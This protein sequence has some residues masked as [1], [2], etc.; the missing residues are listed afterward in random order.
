M[1]VD[2]VG[3]T[4]SRHGTKQAQGQTV[5][6]MLRLLYVPGAWFHHG[7]CAGSDVESAA[8]ARGIGYLLHGHP[9]VGPWRSHA[10]ENDVEEEPEAPLVRNDEIVAVSGI[11]IATPAGRTEVIHSGTWSTIRRARKAQ[12]PH[13]IVWPDGGYNFYCGAEELVR[14]DG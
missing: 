10:I 5:G 14:R 8:R 13:A 6:S 7:C 1:T 4:G 3:F 9:A 12:L 2:R 11:L